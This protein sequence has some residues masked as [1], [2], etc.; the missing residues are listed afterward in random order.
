MCILMQPNTIVS[1]VY[2]FTKAG[3]HELAPCAGVLNIQT[4]VLMHSNQ[5]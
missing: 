2:T 4:A 1:A 5:L 3:T